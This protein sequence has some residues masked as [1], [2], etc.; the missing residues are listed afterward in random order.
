MSKSD[1]RDL[2]M[3]SGVYDATGLDTAELVDRGMAT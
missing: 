1:L 2:L 3:Q